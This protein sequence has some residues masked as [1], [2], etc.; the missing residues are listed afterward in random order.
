MKLFVIIPA[1]NEEKS[2]GNVIDTLHKHNYQNIIVVNDASED[3]TEEIALKK[4]VIV[5]NHII[6]RGQGA[7]LRTGNEYALENGADIIVHFDADGQMRAE[8]IP[9][10]I[11]PILKKEADV[12]IGS[13]FLGKESDIPPSKRVTLKAGRLFLKIFYGAK[14]TDSQCGFRALS[15]KGAQQIVITQDGMAH[16]SEIIAQIFK[17]RVKFKEVPVII[18]YTEYAKAHSHHHRISFWSGVK[19]AFRLILRKLMQ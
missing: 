10:M 1:H 17:K 5:L 2:I 7:A 15:R 6:N 13:R 19:I 11:A 14:L 4:R 12:T 8:D 3:R 18:R 16:A 9:T